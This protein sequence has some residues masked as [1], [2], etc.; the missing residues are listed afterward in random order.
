MER[1]WQ[2]HHFPWGGIVSP[3]FKFSLFSLY[4]YDF[5]TGYN[6]FCKE[7][8]KH[9]KGVP[10]KSYCIVLAQRWK[11]LTEHQRKEYSARC[12]EVW[13]LK[14]FGIFWLSK[15]MNINTCLFQLK[16]QYKNDLDC[17]LMVSWIQKI[18]VWNWSKLAD[19]VIK[20][21]VLQMEEE[22]QT[23][24]QSDTRKVRNIQYFYFDVCFLSNL[25]SCC[26]SSSV[27]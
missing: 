21:F 26:M 13:T 9:I 17:H 11:A 10:K 14:V 5:S 24:D 15:S 20:A 22:K 3:T 4:V 1:C 2:L 27:C 6:L 23:L 19:N 25:N 12:K 16:R 7:Q 8:V 18:L